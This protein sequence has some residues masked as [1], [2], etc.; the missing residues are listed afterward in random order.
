LDGFEDAFAG[1]Y[2]TAYRVAY[3]IVGQR[4]DAEDIAAE[5]MARACERWRKVECYAEPWTVRVAGNLAVDAVRRRARMQ[6]IAAAPTIAEP[7]DRVDLQRALSRLPRRQREVV[8]L[9]FIGDQPET[10]VAEVLGIGLGTVKSH[11]ARGLTALR[12]DLADG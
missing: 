11:A 9:R 3:V 7:L 12:L 10:T 2:R 8:V 6:P 5:T 4:A 1:L